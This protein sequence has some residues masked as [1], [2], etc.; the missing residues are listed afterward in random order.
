MARRTVSVSEEVSPRLRMLAFAPNAWRGPWMNRQHLLSRLGKRHSVLYTNGPWTIWDRQLAAFRSSPFMGAFELQDNVVVDHAPRLLLN[1]PFRTGWGRAVR[2]IACS[3][4]R[5][6]IASLSG[7]PLVAYVFHP[8]YTEYA[9]AMRPDL[10][11]YAPYDLFA[12]TP[13]WGPDQVRQENHLLQVCDVVITVSDAIVTELQARTTSPVFCVP[14]GVDADAF[15]ACTR[16][17]LPEDIA[18]IPRPRI[19]YVGSLNRKVDFGLI[20]RLAA[21]SPSWHFVFVGASF[22]HDERSHSAMEACRQLP[23]VHFLG[24]KPAASLPSYMAALD[25][26]LMCYLAG[27]WMEY[28]CPLKLYE[29]LAAGLPI[30]SSALP[31]MKEFADVARTADGEADWR[32][33]ILDSINRRS[34]ME[35]AARLHVARQNNWDA[36][37]TRIEQIVTDVYLQSQIRSE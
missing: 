28:G 12:S 1:N 19:G 8:G 31:M 26:G 25:V 16:Q 5:H 15:A 34:P 13:D 9:L 11:V 37:V 14:N 10:I 23:N 7:G 18:A 35:T 17:I 36:R 32:S 3:R 29:Y 21:S 33:A 2:L 24:L 6:H 30:V 20:S 27:T 22:G 4:W